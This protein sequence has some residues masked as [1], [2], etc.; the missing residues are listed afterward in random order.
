MLPE[1]VKGLRKKS[2]TRRG[3]RME[4]SNVRRRDSDRFPSHRSLWAVS[5]LIVLLCGCASSEPLVLSEPM[6]TSPVSYTDEVSRRLA[7][8]TFQRLPELY[9]DYRVGAE[10]VLEVSIFEWELREETKSVEIRVSETGV[11]SLP[12]VGDMNVMNLTVEE[13]KA[14]IEKRLKDW[15]IIPNP[16][17]SVVV[18]QFRS[19]RVA[20]VGAVRDPGT[21]TIR[22]NVTTLLDILSLAGGPDAR[23]GQLAYVIRDIRPV[24]SSD[25][26]AG[27]GAAQTAVGKPSPYAGLPFDPSAKEVIAIDLYELL[28]LG[29][30]KLNVLVGNG[31]V[32]NVPE[33]KRFHVI[34]YAR[35]PGSFPLKKPTTVLEGIAM[36]RGFQEIEASKKK[37]VVKRKT[38]EGEYI[39]PVDLVA[40]AKGEAPNFYLQPD[41][42]IYVRQTTL[43]RTL[44]YTYDIVTKMF[45]FTGRLFTL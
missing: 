29:D 40:V 45:T 9:E 39:I 25:V 24:M 19:K 4:R 33:A 15:Q 34:G 6:V 11:I 7:V 36:A 13:I 21:Y 10:D 8:G 16:R 28:E 1:K 3:V 41:D 42:I 5:V 18:Q 30:L 12:V 35:D 31:D 43:R 44:L 32:V 14:K 17:V 37:C 23:A 2:Q 26:G 20:V 27:Q 38:T 22:R